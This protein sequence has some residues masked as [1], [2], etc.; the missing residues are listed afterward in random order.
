[1]ATP[2]LYVG[3]VG[4]MGMRSAECACSILNARE[5]KLLDDE[6]RVQVRLIC[7]RCGT[8]LDSEIVGLPVRRRPSVS[9]RSEAEAAEG[10]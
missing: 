8:V 4:A 10:S 5:E 9:S 2:Q 6:G 7:N 3:R 1:M